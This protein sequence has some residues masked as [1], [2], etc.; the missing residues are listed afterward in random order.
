MNGKTLEK[1]LGHII[2]ATLLRRECL[3]ILRACYAYVSRCYH[4]NGLLWP[5][6]LRE[7]RQI[8]SVLPLLYCNMA[9][10]WYMTVSA[11]DASESGYGVVEKEVPL[12][13]VHRWGRTRERDRFLDPGAINARDHALA[14]LR[15]AGGSPS[16]SSSSSSLGASAVAA[17][18]SA[19]AGPPPLPSP[20]PGLAVA[21]PAGHHCDHH[22][23]PEDLG[24]IVQANDFDHD[25]ILNCQ[26][27]N[28]IDKQVL[29]EDN[30]RL[31]I[32][33]QWN[34]SENILM[35]EARALLMAVR[36]RLRNVSSFGQKHVFLVDNLPLALASGKGRANSRHLAYS[37]R[38]LCAY[39]LATGSTFYVRWV[40]SEFNYA[41]DPSRGL[42]SPGALIKHEILRHEAAV[43]S[44]G[45]SLDHGGYQHDCSHQ[46]C[47]KGGQDSCTQACDVTRPAYDTTSGCRGCVTDSGNIR[48]IVN[49]PKH[50]PIIHG[51]ADNS[52]WI[53][54]SHEHVARLARNN[55]C[56]EP[57]SESGD[58]H[59]SAYLIHLWQ[60]GYA[61]H[62][63]SVLLA[64]ILFFSPTF[65][66]RI[67]VALPG[68]ARTLKG[69]QRARP[70]Q[71]V[72]GIPWI[73]LTGII[74]ILLSEFQVQEALSL[75][76]A[77][78]LYLRPR[79]NTSLIV[80]QLVAPIRISTNYH[81][82]W[83]VLL[84]PSEELLKNKGGR[85]DI[86][87][88]VDSVELLPWIHPFLK[89]LVESR[90]PREKLWTFTHN[91]LIKVFK[92]ALLILQAGKQYKTLYQLRHG[93]ASHDLLHKNRSESQVLQRGQWTSPDTLKRYGK[94]S[95][96]ARDVANL[97]TTTKL[98]GQAISD[99]LEA[100][101]NNPMMALNL[102]NSC[103]VILP[104]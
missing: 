83:S 82:N 54:T 22:Q 16:L 69:W 41:D 47:A 38:A 8:S 51:A 18:A 42:H 1:I 14:A 104:S 97:S 2:W 59:A 89:R 94:P 74:G 93:G 12:G 64:A 99:N 46:D 5:S 50:S 96:M 71:T 57:D 52:H 6:V 60:E 29:T 68:A 98:Y 23:D 56:N 79:E 24:R 53:R 76:L 55:R 31:C 103:N 102:R 27:F 26:V 81:S 58:F 32:R 85:F 25:D 63:G 65:G 35:S 45:K 86:S 67:P 20:P 40:P 80:M 70:L 39:A 43:R 15:P 21:S 78:S 19:G 62:T 77:F 90:N 28:E 75:L 101:F 92:R 33:G 36:H 7:L 44:H 100:C 34:R 49:Q 30:W 9:Q 88:D 72:A 87:I 37:C 10:P 73:L 84:F 91:H 13:I 48:A 95:R 11:S 17:A 66:Q 61:T 3:S 4:E